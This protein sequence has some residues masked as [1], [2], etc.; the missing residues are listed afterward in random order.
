[1]RKSLVDGHCP[2][3][4]QEVP[5]DTFKTDPV[6]RVIIRDGKAVTLSFVQLGVVR[7]LQKRKAITMRELVDEVYRGS[8]APL[9][10]ASSLHVVIRVLNRKLAHV[11]MRVVASHPGREA[12][13]RLQQ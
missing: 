8:E 13:W 10:A 6:Y 11:N 4:G 1:M 3:C 9:T 12:F 2:C 7:A 5:P